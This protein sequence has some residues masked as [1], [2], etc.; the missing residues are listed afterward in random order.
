M[1]LSL[2]HLQHYHDEEY[3]FLSQIA[4]SDETWSHQFEPES[5]HQ[6]KQWK[7]ATSPPPKI[8]NTVY[9]SSG[10]TTVFFFLSQRPTTYRVF[11]TGNHHQCPALPSHF[12]ET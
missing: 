5:K 6:S 8:S 3:G 1:V 2:N 4:T 11:G 12:T 9:T 10:R 7:C